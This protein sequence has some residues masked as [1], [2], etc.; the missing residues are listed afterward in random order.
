MS[1]VDGRSCTRLA[2]ELTNIHAGFVHKFCSIGT[3]RRLDDCAGLNLGVEDRTI[4]TE[5]LGNGNALPI[6]EHSLLWAVWYGQGYAS[7]GRDIERGSLAADWRLNVDAHTPV[8]L[9]S[10]LTLR[11]LERGAAGT[12][13]VLAV[14][15]HRW[16][17]RRAN[18]P[19][20]YISRATNCLSFNH[21]VVTLENRIVTASRRLDGDT[22]AILELVSSITGWLCLEDACLTITSTAIG[23]EWSTEN[24]GLSI[25]FRS[26]RAT[27]DV[28]GRWVGS[29]DDIVKGI[30]SIG[31]LARGILGCGEGNCQ[32]KR[33]RQRCGDSCHDGR[34]P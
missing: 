25:E 6:L 33:E 19:L 28:T 32:C 4:A 15:T 7:R 9:A 8:K 10:V 29:R 1:L 26:L 27:F 14:R 23:T 5:R 31:A 34:R 17:Q 21:T 13:K 2:S 11:D 22:E 24:T 18:V 16:L 20:Q 12:G 3:R 30:F